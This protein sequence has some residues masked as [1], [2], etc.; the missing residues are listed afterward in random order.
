MAVLLWALGVRERG[1]KAE[2]GTG[3]SVRS[4]WVESNTVD[5]LQAHYG[6]RECA[7]RSI[8]SS[9]CHAR[10]HKRGRDSIRGWSAPGRRCA[11]CD[12]VFRVANAS[13]KS[14]FFMSVFALRVYVTLQAPAFLQHC[15]RVQAGRSATTTREPSPSPASG[16]PCPCVPVPPP[17]PRPRSGT[18]LEDM[19]LCNPFQQR[20]SYRRR[21]P[22]ITVHTAIVPLDSLSRGVDRSLVGAPPFRLAA[23]RRL[24]DGHQ[25]RSPRMI[26]PIAS[27]G[28]PKATVDVGLKAENSR[29]QAAV[30]GGAGGWRLQGE[31]G[32]SGY[33]GERP[34]A[35][36]LEQEANYGIDGVEPGGAET[37]GPGAADPSWSVSGERTGIALERELERA[38]C[39]IEVRN[40]ENCQGWVG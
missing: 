5:R 19:E 13:A 20:V 11:R 23:F 39:L 31:E 24:V 12:Q 25:R 9:A 40:R 8:S 37:R 32:I 34:G 6:L 14:S 3:R 28:E 36:E 17:S 29:N 7:L 10:I 4:G 1:T 2:R 26:T 15:S 22:S 16:R 30:G 38:G 18:V 35:G 27:R 21:L 33:D